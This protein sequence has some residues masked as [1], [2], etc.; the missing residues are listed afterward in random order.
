M[1]NRITRPISVWIAQI[2]MIGGA[3]LFFVAFLLVIFMLTSLDETYVAIILI[4]SAMY[5]GLMGLFIA[6]FVGMARRK[7]WGLWL[8]VGLL[9]LM[10]IFGVIGQ[11]M[12]PSGPIQRYEYDNAREA[13]VGFMTGIFILGLILWLTLSLAFGKRARSFF[14]GTDLEAPPQIVP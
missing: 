4:A 5:L 6:A 10:V 7:Q 1:E 12:Q 8:A 14:S 11:I 2:V 9:S 13:A 3:V